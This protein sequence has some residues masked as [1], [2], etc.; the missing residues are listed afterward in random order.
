[1]PWPVLYQWLDETYPDSKFVLW[2]RNG[3]EWAASAQGGLGGGAKTRRM[4]TLDYGACRVQDLPKEQL[5]QVYEGHVRSV[6][7]YFNGTWTPQQRKDRF[8]EFDMTTP[9]AANELCDFLSIGKDCSEF[10]PMP[11]RNNGQS[12]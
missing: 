12:N 7:T 8:L 3:S 6:R 5:I 1:M 11:H 4:M 10:G 9:T 2:A